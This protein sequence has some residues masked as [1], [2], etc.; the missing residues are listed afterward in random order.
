MIDVNRLPQRCRQPLEFLSL[1]RDD[2]DPDDE[3]ERTLHGGGDSTHALLHAVA[4]GAYVLP[5]FCEYCG[6]RSVTDC[7][8]SR[9]QRPQL[10]FSKK[11]PPF[12]N[13]GTAHTFFDPTTDEAY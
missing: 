10:Y 1:F 7:D 11:R 13:A 6:A 12:A 4:P 3:L 9:C 8:P 5:T 2:I